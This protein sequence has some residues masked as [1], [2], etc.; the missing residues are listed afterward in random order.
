MSSLVQSTEALTFVKTLGSD[1]NT[2]SSEEEDYG[3]LSKSEELSLQEAMQRVDQ[4]KEVMRNRLQELEE[5]N[6]T[7]EHS[8]EDSNEDS[9]SSDKEPTRAEYA[10]MKILAGEMSA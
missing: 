8:K 2:D 1:I 4:E 6:A 10:A 9:E 7:R 3:E 5:K